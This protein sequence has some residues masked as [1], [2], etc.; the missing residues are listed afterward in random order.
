[1]GG[2]VLEQSMIVKADPKVVSTP[3]KSG[4]GL[5]AN[6]IYKPQHISVT[7]WSVPSPGVGN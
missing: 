1:M 4:H 7:S 2:S 3:A 6:E 5:G